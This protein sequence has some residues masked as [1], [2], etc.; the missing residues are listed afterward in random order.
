GFFGRMM[1]AGNVS[2]GFR[3]ADIGGIKIA[4][5]Q[6]GRNTQAFGVANSAIGGDYAVIVDQACQRR[7]RVK[8]A[9]E[10]DRKLSFGLHGAVIARPVGWE[11]VRQEH[12]FTSRLG[13]DMSIDAS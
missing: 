13:T 5:P 7:V 4:D 1:V 8:I 2:V 12:V 11:K 9:I 10:K 6:F 3:Q